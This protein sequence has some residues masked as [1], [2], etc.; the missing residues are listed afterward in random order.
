M[1][2]GLLD[3][4]LARVDEHDG[5]VRRRGAGHH[6][7]RVL[8]VARRVGDDELAPRRREVAVRH[9]DRDPLFPLGAQA[10]REQR[11][12]EVVLAALLSRALDRLKLV[13][14]DRLGIVEE[15]TDQGRLAVVDAAGGREPQQIHREVSRVSGHEEKGST[16]AADSGSQK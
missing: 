4:A 6:V 8:D 16:H 9:I 2:A 5:E 14:E 12:I 10:V 1:P 3:Y 15:T 7:A 13:L 11:E